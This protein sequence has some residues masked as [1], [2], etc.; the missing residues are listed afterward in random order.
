[1]TK[2]QQSEKKSRLCVESKC[3]P[4]RTCQTQTQKIPPTDMAFEAANG[5]FTLKSA[6]RRDRQRQSDV[7]A[8]F[9]VSLPISG[10]SKLIALADGQVRATRQ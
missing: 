8:Y 6:I 1:V 2:R 5:L 9:S 4:Q 7:L 10:C 3:Q